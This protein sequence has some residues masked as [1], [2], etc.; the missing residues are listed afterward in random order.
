MERRKSKVLSFILGE[1]GIVLT[2]LFLGIHVQAAPPEEKEEIKVT[3]NAAVSDKALTVHAESEN[4]IKSI[5]ING[6]EFKNTGNGNLKIMLSQ[7]DA[8]YNKFYIYAEDNAG[9]VSELYEVDNPYFDEDLTDDKNPAKE[10]PIDPSATDPTQAVGT[11]DE[12]LFNGGREFYQISTESGKVFYLIVDMLSDEEKVYFLTEISEN[13][14]LNVTSD[15][16]QTLPRNSAIPEDGIPEGAVVNNNAK[17]STV[18]A[19]FGK[20]E[21]PVTE[22][23]KE[24]TE[25]ETENPKESDTKGEEEMATVAAVGLSPKTI[26]YMIMA[27][28]GVGVIIGVT[29]VK[30]K[31]RNNSKDTLDTPEENEEEE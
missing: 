14:L 10:L 30:K 12:H 2:L 17:G 31:K 25:K 9:L 19:L 18:E 1:L 4:G 8:G 24:E 6:Y 13:D 16:S 26:I 15:T 3:L 28:I 21:A 27:V 7:F 11:V 23:I 5:Y 29:A 22:E 20:K